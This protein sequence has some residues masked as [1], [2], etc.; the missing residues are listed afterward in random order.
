MAAHTS[1]ASEAPALNQTAAFK[2]EDAGAFTGAI[3]RRIGRILF[4]LIQFGELLGT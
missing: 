4:A 2:V 1:W 3:A